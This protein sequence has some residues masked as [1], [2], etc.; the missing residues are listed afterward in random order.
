MEPEKKLETLQDEIKLLKGELK[1]SLVSV[2]DYLLNMELP[3]SEFSTILAAL[4]SEGEQ[5]MVMKGSLSTP[6]PEA[7]RDEVTEMEE[8]ET[9]QDHEDESPENEDTPAADIEDGLPP[10]NEADTIE[11]YPSDNEPTEPEP[12][13]EEEL[14]PRDIEEAIAG[15]NPEEPSPEEPYDEQQPQPE[16]EETPMDYE[17]TPNV[18]INPGI[19]KVNMLANLLSW[20]AKARKDIGPE[21]IPV[22]LEVY[23]LSGYLSPEFKEVIMHLAD[24]TEERTEPASYAEIWSQLM[25]SLHGILTGGDIPQHPLMPSPNETKNEVRQAEEEIIEVDKPGEKSGEKPVKLK[26]VLPDSDGKGQE[27][28]IDLTPEAGGKVTKDSHTV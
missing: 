26:L 25:L 27:F 5:R 20:V 16:T 24:M 12:D 9:L 8:E 2:R 10:E 13:I 7:P 14:A 18:D 3:S 21:Q 23:G 22:F 15:G 19:P 17:K 6:E 11:D 28:C 1:Q 4:G